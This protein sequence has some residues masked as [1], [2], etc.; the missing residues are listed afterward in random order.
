MLFGFEGSNLKDPV[1]IAKWKHLKSFRTQKLSTSAAK[2]VG[3]APANIAR[4]RVFF[5]YFCFFNENV[6]IVKKRLTSYFNEHTMQIVRKNKGA[7]TRDE[8]S[9]F[10]S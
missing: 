2:I 6:P 4:C 8:A 7:L 9:R 1:A 3:P 5:Y 10:T